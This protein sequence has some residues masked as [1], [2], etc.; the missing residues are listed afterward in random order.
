MDD[1]EL[2][3]KWRQ[4]IE[5]NQE[6]QDYFKKYNQ[7]SIS[8][9]IDNYISS[10]YLAFTYAD[11][12]KNQ[13]ES[14]YGKWLDKAH[15]HLEIILQKKLFD[16]QCLWRAEQL[17]IEGLEL[18]C[19]FYDWSSDVFNCP[20]IEPIT[21]VELEMYQNYLLQDTN[22][23]GLDTMDYQVY[24]EI[25]EEYINGS[26]NDAMPEWY[27]YHNLYTGGS[28]LLLLPDIRGEKEEFYKTFVREKNKKKYADDIEKGIT[29]PYDTRP[30]LSSYPKENFLEFAKIADTKE[31]IKQFKNFIEVDKNHNDWLEDILHA[32]ENID[33]YIPIEAHHDYKEAIKIA[34]HKYQNKKIIEH[35]PMAFENYLFSKNMGVDTICKQKF[36]LKEQVAQMIYDGREMN[37]EPRDLNF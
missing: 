34:Y 25:K 15:E 30:H 4:E 35:L 31:T 6:A 22:Y 17:V 18:C 29:T 20:F 10:K 26:E 32:M 3:E 11:F 19:E 24:E 14:N 23:L 7:H 1:K 28:S 16:M 9:F 27:A 8:G 36:Y 2:K 5:N 33:E 13:I 37:G 21:K 12:H